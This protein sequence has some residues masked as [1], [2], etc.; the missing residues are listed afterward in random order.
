MSPA[1]RRAALLVVLAAALPATALGQHG[2]GHAPSPPGASDG[3]EVVMQHATFAPMHVSVLVGERVRWTNGSGR[4]HTVT[5]SQ[6]GLFDSGRVGVDGRFSH[7]FAA[8]GSFGYVC[9]L[10]PGMT[11]TVDVTTLL[12]RPVSTVVRGE[13]LGLGGRGTPGGGAVTIQRDGGAGAGFATVVTV[14]RK[15]DGSFYAPLTADTT[16][17]FRA[18]SGADVSAPVRVEVA[19]RRTLTVSTTRGDKRRVVRVR[20]RPSAPGSVVH[21]QRHLR[22]RFGWWTVARRTLNSTGRAR[23]TLRR[24]T[25]G[26]IRMQLT[27]PDGE[28]PVA[29]SRT[30]RLR[31]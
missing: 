30:V 11:G 5:S 6:G 29:V 12:L 26:A 8:R 28:T 10:H 22:E 17:T 31:G 3:A 20:V 16:A 7:A 9:V 25:K 21:L 13:P 18:V 23:F 27:K 4:S 1:I 19:E 15:M 14:P 24:G 2:G